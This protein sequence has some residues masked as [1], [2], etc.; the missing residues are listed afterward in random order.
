MG[1]PAYG[2]GKL[3]RESSDSS[4]DLHPKTSLLTDRNT[5]VILNGSRADYMQGTRMA[6]TTKE[7]AIHFAEKQGAFLSSFTLSFPRRNVRS[8]L[9]TVLRMGLLRAATDREACP[10]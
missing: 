5:A 10:A 1:E 3:V 8:L 6:F 4:L 7:D 9:H 2:M